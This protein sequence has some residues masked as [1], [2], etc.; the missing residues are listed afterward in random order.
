MSE[1]KKVSELEGGSVSISENVL[2][3]IANIATAEICGVSSLSG[4]IADG[5]SNIFGK[6]S[7]MKGVR[8]EE[9]DVG[10]ELNLSIIVNYGSDIPKIC[11]KVQQAAKQAVLD[12][13]SLEVSKVNI[14][15]VD[16]IMN[17]GEKTEK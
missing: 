8:I 11:N 9:T 17:V 13:T 6:K 5:V 4:G 3:T 7:H 10:L 2:R 1:I 15:V 12:M 14:E 16:I